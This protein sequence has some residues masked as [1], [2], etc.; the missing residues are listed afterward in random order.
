M[1]QWLGHRRADWYMKADLAE[2]EWRAGISPKLIGCSCEAVLSSP[3]AERKQTW[4]FA[5]LV[6]AALDLGKLDVAAAHVA[7][8][9]MIRSLN[10]WRIPAE[11]E[12]V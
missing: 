9:R 11:V 6:R 3:Q 1:R 2:L 12:A 7:L 5:T 8:V 4:C 10:G